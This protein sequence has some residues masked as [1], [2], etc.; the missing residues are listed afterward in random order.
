MHDMYIYYR[1]E[2][3]KVGMNLPKVYSSLVFC[4]PRTVVVPNALFNE[5][6]CY[7]SI[8]LHKQPVE[9]IVLDFWSRKG[10]MENTCLSSVVDG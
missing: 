9:N 5:L 10:T 1:H 3:E 6:K 4:L 7:K 8:Y 2:R